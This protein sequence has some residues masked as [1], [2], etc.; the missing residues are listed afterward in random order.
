[1]NTPV[2]LRR[3]LKFR[4]VISTST[5]LAFAAIG[6]LSCV[7]IASMLGGDSGWIALTIA[8][9]LAVLAALCFSEL[10][11]LYPSAAAIRLYMKEAFN[12]NFSLI[13]TFGYLITIIL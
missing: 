1:M 12:D 3:V 2:S 13:I 6:L 5:G 10:N 8:G 4:T 9:L 7:Q 11:A